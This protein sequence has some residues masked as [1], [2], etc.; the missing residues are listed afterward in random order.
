MNKVISLKPVA[1][2]LGLQ[3]EQS[4][5]VS[6]MASDTPLLNNPKLMQAVFS[7]DVLKNKRNTEAIEV[8]P[9]VLAVRAFA[10]TQSRLA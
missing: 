7:D 4:A 10:G 3:V 8:A 1:Q 5:W 2:Q 9:N 6:R